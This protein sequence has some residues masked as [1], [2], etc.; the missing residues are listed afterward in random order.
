MTRK[1][2]FHTNL[3]KLIEN[4]GKSQIEI[5]DAIGE[6]YTTF[7]M[8]A[9]GGTMPRADKL[10]KIADYFH[11]GLDELMN[12]DHEIFIK[13]DLSMTIEELEGLNPE[14]LARVRKYIE[15]LKFEGGKK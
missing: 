2:I 11:V 15:F 7:N 6:K 13:T 14:Q 1:E 12:E 3:R 9:L 10:Q 8:W 4:S 5:A